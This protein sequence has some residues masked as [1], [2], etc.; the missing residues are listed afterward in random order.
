MNT[1]YILS[2]N[3][4]DSTG[5]SGIQADIKAIKDLG[6]YA[7]TAITSVTVQNKLGISL[8]NEMPTDTVIGQIRAVYEDYHPKAVKIGMVNNAETIRK[9]RDEIIGCRNIVC[10]PVII[11]SGGA[12]LMNEESIRAFRQYLLPC[13]RLLV[14]KSEEAEL[15]LSRK[16]NTDADM[17]EA[18]REIHSEGVEYVLL[19]GSHHTEGR[20]TTLLYAYG[21]A[22]FFSSYNIEGW[23]RHGVGG[24]FSTSLATRLALG[25]TIDEAL[26]NAHEYLHNQIVYSVESGDY[27]VRPQEIYNK[28]MS[29]I[30]QHYRN[31]HDVTF[32]ADR[33]SITTRY[34]AQITKTVVSKSPKEIIDEYLLLQSKN[35]LQNTSLSIKEISDALGF[36]SPILFSR[37][38]RQKE[39]ATPKELRNRP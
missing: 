28:Y 19:R 30:V 12:M 8:V 32:Y 17:I 37:F 1:T 33:L 18:A 2:I 22:R 31:N 35:M 27:G 20:I 24:A 29:L 39:G 13:A 36:S 7:L 11:S 6:G 15:V 3:G 23:K 14:T 9:I 21:E 26:A 38:I 25:D 5:M 34:L 4:S 10:S 16:I